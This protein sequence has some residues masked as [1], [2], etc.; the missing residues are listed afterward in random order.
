MARYVHRDRRITDASHCQ[1]CGSGGGIARPDA[2]GRRVH[3]ATTC[4]YCGIRTCMAVSSK[5]PR[6]YVGLLAGWSGHSGAC[7]RATCEQPRAAF[8]RKRYICAAH[9]GLPQIPDPKQQHYLMRLVEVPDEIELA[10]R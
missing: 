3:P 2:S 10:A 6:C 4:L 9:A 1:L 8:I 7:Q 5:C